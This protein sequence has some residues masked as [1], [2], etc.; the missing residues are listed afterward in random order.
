MARFIT[1]NPKVVIGTNQVFISL[2]KSIK[3]IIKPLNLYPNNIKRYLKHYL[4]RRPNQMNPKSLMAIY[5]LKN[6]VF[7]RIQKK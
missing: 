5:T 2:G 1:W 6:E 7:L 3:E 4:S